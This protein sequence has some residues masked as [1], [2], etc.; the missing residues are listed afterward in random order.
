M[1]GFYQG[2]V[3]V[4]LYWIAR[5]FIFQRSDS[6]L[7]IL[8]PRV[9]LLISVELFTLALAS[10]KPLHVSIVI[11]IVI[12]IAVVGKVIKRLGK[13]LLF[14]SGFAIVIFLLNFFAGQFF[15]QGVT[16][17]N[18]IVFALRFIAIVGSTSLFFLTTSPDELEHVMKW[19]RL[20]R[21]AIFAFVTA[22]RF[23]PVLMLDAVMI[24]DAQKSRGLELE[25]G[26]LLKRVKNFIPILIPLVVNA[27]IRS[28]EL[29]EAMESRAYGTVK[30]PTSLHYLSMGTLD[31][32]VSIL[33]V[34]CFT[35][36]IYFFYVLS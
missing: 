10:F 11:A 16:F 29:A 32:A 8:D 31:S 23:V 22:V 18:A 28:G 9:R 25:K 1:K 17:E 33:S 30:R 27:V 14:A 20:P 12:G 13:P 19:F 26:R 21:D 4:R 7:Q 24:M 35:I 2:C 5:G 6:R 36:L 34:T 15:G 3:V